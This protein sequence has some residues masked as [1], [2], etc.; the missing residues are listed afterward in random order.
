METEKTLIQAKPVTLSMSDQ[1]EIITFVKDT[2][3]KGHK[4][5][6]KYKDHWEKCEKAYHC[7]MEPIESPELD[8]MSNVCLPWAYDASESW[9]AHIHST[10]IP[11]NDQV[12]T[13]SGR[14][15]EDHPGSE[16]M[17][18]YM[19]YRFQENKY[20]Q[21]LGKA[22]DQ[23]KIRN[24]TCQ[25]VYWRT[26]K[27]ID[28]QWVDEPVTQ[29]VLDPTQGIEVPMQVGTK[30]VRR[31][32]EKVTFNNVWIDVVDINNFVMYPI[33]G[34]INKT[35]RIHE[36]YKHYEDLMASADETNYFNLDKLSIDDERESTNPER[37]EEG[38]D[39][40]KQQKGLNIKEA[41]IYRVKINDKVYRNYV[42][43]V[44]NDKWLIRFQPFP[45]SCPNSPF[46]WMSLRPDGDCL[47]GYGL[48]SKGLQIL[49]AANKK[50]NAWIDESTLT[51]HQAHAY[52]EDGVYN[53]HNVVRRPGAQ[54]KM[55][56]DSVIEGNLRPLIDDIG[57]QQQAMVD[58]AAL[59]VEFE[60]V[61]IPKVVKGM[62]ETQRETTA[63]EQ[64]IAQNN[65][66]GKMHIDAYN[67][68]DF[69]IKTTLELS[70]EAIYQRTQFDDSIVEEIKLITQPK[71]ANGM[72]M[73]D[74][75]I[76]PL[77]EVDIKIV[78]YQN[79]IRKQETLQA[80]NLIIPQAMQSPWAKYLKGYD[81]LETTFRLADVDADTLLVKKEQAGQI[82]QQEQQASQQQQDLLVQQETA[83]LDL[84]KEK[85]DQDFQIKLQE[86]ELRRL[87]LELK[88]QQQAHSEQM[89]EHNAQLSE[90]QAGL[91]ERESN[92]RE[93]A[94]KKENKNNG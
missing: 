79:V 57:R 25:K 30:K 80:M 91:A 55:T 32:Q 66:V 93:Q 28:Y 58:L 54:V 70:Y 64:N 69:I 26:D 71:D 50:F 82:D 68:N 73:G 43:T 33:H 39:D 51:Q 62:I 4:A 35:T 17:Q 31:P 9:Y 63:T 5:R 77:P 94:A 38:Q 53:P 61:T 48:N 60:T 52:W 76:L 49:D 81:V 40:C 6:K 74:L 10:T 13:I 20:A 3:D 27:T 37:K 44:V 34:D 11:K 83:K 46:V 18:K 90:H 7:E 2:S 14:T 56:K 47:Y 86:L 85:Q 42:A 41:W 88:F 89:A 87:E 59:K 84:Q 45:A 72:P 67:I 75:P 21:Q 24:H 29:M 15:E 22:Y 12:F 65:S 8:W 23:L 16:V 92:T 36:T 1:E 19:E 78:G